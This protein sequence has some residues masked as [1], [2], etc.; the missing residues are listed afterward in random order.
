MADKRDLRSAINS[1]RRGRREERDDEVEEGREV[2][3]DDIREMEDGDIP[4]EAVRVSFLATT[5]FQNW[6]VILERPYPSFYHLCLPPP[7]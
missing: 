6:L 3:G 1:L 4:A 5:E 7:V 2:Q